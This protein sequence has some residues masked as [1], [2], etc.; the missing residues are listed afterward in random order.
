MYLQS[1]PEF[2]EI[3]MK[4]FL[5]S[6]GDEITGTACQCR[7]FIGLLHRK[8]ADICYFGICQLWQAAGI[9][10]KFQSRTVSHF[11]KYEFQFSAAKNHYHVKLAT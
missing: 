6:A 2:N 9:S 5:F 1:F 11:I 10:T 4:L 8:R 3:V 7:S